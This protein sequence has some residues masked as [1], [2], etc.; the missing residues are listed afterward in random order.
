M[1]DIFASIAGA[2][3]T[4]PQSGHFSIFPLRARATAA[5]AATMTPPTARLSTKDPSAKAMTGRAAGITDF[6]QEACFRA[7]G[8]LLDDEWFIHT[9][10]GAVVRG[11]GRILRRTL[12]GSEDL[13]SVPRRLGRQPQRPYRRP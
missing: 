11:R 7:G 12:E 5:I 3:K 1:P 8:H 4:V 6:L 13:D 10:A 2:A 9:G